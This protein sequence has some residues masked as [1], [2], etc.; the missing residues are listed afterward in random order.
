MPRHF[1]IVLFALLLVGAPVA[2]EQPDD[3]EENTVEVSGVGEF[4]YVD[5]L[6]HTIQY[7]E[8]GTTFD[9]VDQGGQDVLF[10]FG[11]LS[12]ELEVG[13]RHTFILLYQPLQFD[14]RVRLRRDVVVDEAT[15]EEGTPVDL[16]YN[17]PFYRATYLYDLVDAQRSSLGVGGSLQIRNATISFETA[18]G[19]LRRENRDTGLVPLLQLRGD[20]SVGDDWWIG[21]EV[22]GF[23]A[24]IQYLNLSDTDV[25]GAIWDASLRAGVD[26]A[27]R[28]DVFLNARYL[29]G[30]ARGT[31]ES[32]ERP[33]DGFVENWLH[34]VTL[35]VGADFEIR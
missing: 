4:G 34:L 27:D 17:F 21:T 23:Y 16:L 26:V 14:T 9:Y 30:A 22:G 1:W 12:A 5:P 29:G 7:G 32:E 2:A 25:M 31:S 19:M 11:R 13:E 15:F 3:D 35:S 10:P 24:P 18:D 33:G 28:T 8:D 20:R 6:Y